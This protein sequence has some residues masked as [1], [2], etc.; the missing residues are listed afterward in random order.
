MSAALAYQFVEQRATPRFEIE[1][2]ITME[3]QT[4]FYT[5]FSENVSEGGV[6]VAMHAP[7]AVGEIVRLRVHLDD[8]RDVMA[9][10]QVRWHRVDE[11]GEAIGAGIQFVSLDKQSTAMLQWMMSRAGQA[12]LLME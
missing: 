11:R 6:F 9:A 3:S 2:R 12:P 1:A 8:G 10:G 5:G 4:N 7:P